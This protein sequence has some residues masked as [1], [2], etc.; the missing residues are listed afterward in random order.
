MGDN[1]KIKDF[2]QSL[3]FH[4]GLNQNK[5][6][7]PGGR[8]ALSVHNL[9]KFYETE[10]K[11]DNLEN[12]KKAQSMINYLFPIRTKAISLSHKYKAKKYKFKGHL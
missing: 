5:A 12:R 10:D 1:T 7:V 8:I 3:G 11:T 4:D 2:L 6:R 9:C